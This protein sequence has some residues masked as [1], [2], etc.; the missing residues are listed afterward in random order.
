MAASREKT[1]HSYD[2]LHRNSIYFSFSR[3][4]FPHSEVQLRTSHVP[5]N[6]SLN[7]NFQV[8]R[9][10]FPTFKVLSKSVS[11]LQFFSKS[12][13]NFQYI[14]KSASNFQLFPNLASN[15]QLFTKSA[16]NFQL[17]YHNL[18]ADRPPLDYGTEVGSWKPNL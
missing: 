14:S 6:F 16:S 8:F 2:F 18:G 17:Q 9:K 7:S 5:S 1:F 15:F 4:P 13:S 10:R 11:N 12:A 3:L